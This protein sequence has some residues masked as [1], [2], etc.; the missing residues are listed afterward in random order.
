MDINVKILLIAI[1]IIWII[2]LFC[3]IYLLVYFKVV[4]FLSTVGDKTFNSE[5]LDKTI[6]DDSQQELP[7]EV[8][9]KH[10]KLDK[11]NEFRL[12]LLDNKNI[13]EDN[14][15]FVTFLKE[16]D[17]SIWSIQVNSEKIRNYGC[18]LYTHKKFHLT[19]TA[20]LEDNVKKRVEK[21]LRGVE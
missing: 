12:R 11:V 1:M 10:C 19:K 13:L 3:I 5:V 14:E 9:L 2:P 7:Y 17:A 21:E 16:L 8:V 15:S 18:K 4:E 20:K 6:I